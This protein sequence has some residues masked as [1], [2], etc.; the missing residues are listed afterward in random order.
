M[1]GGGK[2]PDVIPSTT[3]VEEQQVDFAGVVRGMEV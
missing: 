3:R 2:Y 1:K